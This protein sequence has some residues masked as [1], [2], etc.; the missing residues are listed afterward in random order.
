MKQFLILFK[1]DLLELY[2]T[3]KILILGIVFLFF[4]MLSPVFAKMMPE[5]IGLVGDDIVIELPEITIMHS[6]DQF[7]KNF[8]QI[9][10]FALVIT[11]GGL[12]V[13]EKKKGLYNSLI[14]NGILKRNFVLAKIFSQL[15]VITVIYLISLILFSLYNYILFDQVVV[16]YMFVS[17]FSFYMYLVF[18]IC[19]V[20][21][22][23]AI[24]KSSTV[25]LVMS[26]ATIFGSLLFD[27][28]KFGKYLPN[29]LISIATQVIKDGSFMDYFLFN[30]II[31]SFICLFLIIGS[32]KLC[33]NL[34]N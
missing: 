14:N 18:L 5:I 13:N 4:A 32:I 7:F 29:Y 3:K 34:E 27:L 2:R 17:L 15:L 30:I 31:T 10:I 8:T 21:F 23:S 33:S 26:F 22:F 9:G 19:L 16:D 24:F 28:F 11:F 12:I 6:F 25:V 20:N 1:K